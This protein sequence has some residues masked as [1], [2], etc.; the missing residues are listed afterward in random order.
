MVIDTSA[1]IAILS[2]ESDA[3]ILA[4]TIESVTVRRI[5]AASLLEA[6]IVIEK[7]TGTL[8]GAKLDQF[9]AEADIQIEPVTAEQSQIA[10][11]AFR[12]YGKGRHPAALNF[13]DCFSY[14]LA[15]SVGEPLLFKGNDFSQTDVKLAISS[16]DAEQ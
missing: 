14:A 9:V 8:G 16:S 10:R 3:L 2:S 5:S 15:K 12:M 4:R 7:R 6:A 13:G 1:V 11:L